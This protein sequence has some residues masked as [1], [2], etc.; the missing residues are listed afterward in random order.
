V[1]GFLN[2]STSMTLNDFELP[3]PKKGF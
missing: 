3:P 1:T 2:L